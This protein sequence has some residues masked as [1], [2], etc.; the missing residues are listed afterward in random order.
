MLKGIIIRQGT[1]L[2]SILRGML[3]AT[4]PNNAV[5]SCP[6]SLVIS[7]ETPHTLICESDALRAGF[8]LATLRG[9]GRREPI[10]GPGGIAEGI[11]IN[12][13]ITL[14]EDQGGPAHRYPISAFIILN[15][16]GGPV[17]QR[18]VVG[19]DIAGAWETIYMDFPNETV[20]VHVN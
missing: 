17:F 12:I 7:P 5:L 1:R 19:G 11:P 4:G 14:F 6:L 8:N 15:P 10:S 9:T 2:S 16:P 13:V 20:T 3:R 18:S